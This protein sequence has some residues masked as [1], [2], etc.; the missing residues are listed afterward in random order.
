MK[1][2][3]IFFNDFG[4]FFNKFEKII[5]ISSVF[6]IR[7]DIDVFLCVNIYDDEEARVVAIGCGCM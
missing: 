6:N 5:F 2:T 7:I 3:L 1:T 4:C